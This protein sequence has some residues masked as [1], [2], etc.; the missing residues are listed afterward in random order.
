MADS[1]VTPDSTT[2]PP[3]GA[4]GADSGSDDSTDWKGEARKWEAR[5][6]KNQEDLTGAQSTLSAETT[7]AN[8][9]EA[10]VTRR[11]VALEH[12]LSTEDAA[13]LDALTDE[14][15][16]KAL[17]GRLATKVETPPPGRNR[18]PREGQNGAPQDNPMREVVRGLFKPNSS[19]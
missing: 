3:A 10:K 11:D 15:A 5:A 8:D 17:A 13:L 6:K 1:T 18:S 7:R 16:M 2:P 4:P 12:H 19:T 14:A 9:A